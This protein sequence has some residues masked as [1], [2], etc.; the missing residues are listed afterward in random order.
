MASK[1][2]NA[3]V[4]KVMREYKKGTLKSSSGSKVKSKAQAIAIALS[5]QRAANKKRKK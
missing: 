3:K 4:Q 2:K 1:K 5:E